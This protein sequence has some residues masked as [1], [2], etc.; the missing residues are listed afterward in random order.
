MNYKKPAFW[1]IVLAVIATI[2]LGA[3]DLDLCIVHN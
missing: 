2:V 3:F 1:M